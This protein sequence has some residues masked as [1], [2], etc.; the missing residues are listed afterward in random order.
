[1][2]TLFVQFGANLTHLWPKFVIP[3]LEGRIEEKKITP[4]F[5]N[6]KGSK[7]KREKESENK[8][9]FYREEGKKEDMHTETQQAGLNQGCQIQTQIESDL[10]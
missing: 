3:Q 10:P 2:R 9:E 7:K 6:N 4:S 1:M 8:R 5:M